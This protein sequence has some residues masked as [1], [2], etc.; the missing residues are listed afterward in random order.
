MTA[1]SIITTLVLVGISLAPMLAAAWDRPG[2]PPTRK[3][4]TSERLFGTD[5]ADPYR[6]LEDGQS[7]EVKAWVDKQNDLTHS[8]LDHLSGREAIRRR[9]NDLLSI[10]SLGTPQPAKGHY[11]YT[12]RTGKENQAILYVREG[13]Q[14]K[15]R[16]LID[17]N[18]LAADGTVAL[19]WWFPSRD[20]RY[21]AYGLSANGSEQSVLHVLDVE[22]GKNL[23]DIIERTQACSVAWLPDS[24]AFYYTRYPAA[25]TVP[26]QEEKYHRH[27]FLHVLGAD[28]AHDKDTF[29]AERQP[30]DWPDVA[31]SPDGRWLVVTVEMGWS[32]SEVYFKDLQKAGAPFVPLVE[33]V[34]ALFTVVVRNDRFYV[35]TNEQAPR[36]RLFQVDPL[37]PER[38]EWT[39]LLPESEDVLEGVAVIGKTLA[40]LYMHQASSRLRLCDDAGKLIEEVKLPTLGTVGGLR[41][42]WDGNELF[43]GFDS[44]TMPTGVYHVD[45]RDRKTDLWEKVPA[46]LDWSR[47]EVEQV[48]YPSKDGTSITMFLAHKK[49]LERNSRNPTLLSAYGGFNVNITPQFSPSRFLFLEAGGLIAIPNLRGGGEFGEGWHRAGMLDKKQNV[50]DD[51]VSAALWLIKEK[52]TSCDRL[53][54][55]GGSNGGLLMGAALTQR[56][57]LFRAVVCQ[58]PLLDMIRYHKFLIARLWIPEYGSADDPEQFT[59]LYAYSPYHHVH[60]GTAYP[61]VLLTAAE[62]DTRVDALHARKMAARL[63]AATASDQ[64]ILLR[65]ETK[66]GHGAGKP[67]AKLLDELTDEWSFI[68]WQLG[69]KIYTERGQE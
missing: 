39:E 49:G 11:F 22:T 15:Q 1:R 59:W 67:R 21:V 65:I 34:P 47:Y 51:F 53:A 27:V 24:K 37:A 14:G 43:F 61:A 29:G 6:W 16:V 56:P 52:Y 5:V 54:I 41:G 30:E 32:M 19:D 20:G 7:S 26:K 69:L 58:V 60:S 63:Q 64:P 17:P 35:H 12:K 3:E 28:P 18:A 55:Q 46:D 4:K 62:S 36:Y 33:K 57:D 45:L 40:A 9:L 8:V 31:L 13:L 10:G 42:E 48:R 2:Y 38:K 66:A 25:G 50:F 68:F 44:F 23:S